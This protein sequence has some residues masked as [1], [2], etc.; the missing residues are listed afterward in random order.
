MESPQNL[1]RDDLS[2]RR[3]ELCAD[4][5]S[6]VLSI[7]DPDTY[8]LLVEWARDELANQVDWT[9]DMIIT[10]NE[11][12]NTAHMVDDVIADSD[13]ARISV[14]SSAYLLLVHIA[15]E[16]EEHQIQVYH[17]WVDGGED[18]GDEDEEDSGDEDGP[19]KG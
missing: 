17:D 18:S 2:R 16:A 13:A 6:G 19:F 8:Q 7:Q 9:D 12:L 3:R 15:G 1:V 14:S 4:L 5:V 10:F 11:V